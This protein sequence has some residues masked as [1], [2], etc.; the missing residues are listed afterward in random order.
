MRP[1]EEEELAARYRKFVHGQKI[2]ECMQSAYRAVDTDEIGRALRDVE[3]GLRYDDGLQQIVDGLA[4]AEN[5]LND[6]NRSI[7]FLPVS[8]TFV[9]NT[10]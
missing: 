2:A 4:D 1:G 10:G 6:L 3:S 9:L 8:A 5:I 7:L